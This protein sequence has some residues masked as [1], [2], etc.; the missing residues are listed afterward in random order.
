MTDFRILLRTSSLEYRVVK[1]TLA[2]RAAEGSLLDSAKDL[3]SGPVGLAISYDD[4]ILLA[5]KVL[6]YS[7]TNDKLTITGGAVEGEVC[8]LSKLKA[9]SE[10]PSREVLLSMIASAMQSPLYRLA[11]VL[12]AALLR[13]VHAMAALKNKRE[14]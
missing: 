3:F 5:K 8:D 1:N 14:T 11:T 7:I 9:L 10:L 4:P 6:E 13:I 2:R 12:N